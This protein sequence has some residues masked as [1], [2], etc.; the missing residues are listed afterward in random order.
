MPL[1]KETKQTLFQ[2]AIMIDKNI[3]TS[4]CHIY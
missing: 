3:K 2:Q 1:N 4:K